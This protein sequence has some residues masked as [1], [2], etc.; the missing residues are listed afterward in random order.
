M[1]PTPE[2]SVIIVGAGPTG[3]ALACELAAA[4]VSCTVLER[5]TKPSAQ[6]RAMA[7]YSRTLEVLDLRGHA[8][9]L[10]AVGRPVGRM[11]PAQGAS[12]DFTGIDSPFPALYVVP[13]SR[14]EEALQQ[15]AI[16]LGVIV[17]RGAEVFGVEQDATG[18][19]L[20]VRTESG[21]WEETA[22][23]VVGCDGA[24]SAVREMS[25]IAFRG[26]TYDIAPILADVR[27][28]K[29]P[30]DD[31]VM[32]TGGGAM[33]VS[34]PFG[35]GL[36]RVAVGHRDHPWT[37]DE[38]TLEELAER[39][40]E[41]LG[42]DPEPYDAQ[43]LAR[44]KIHQR[45]ADQYR[46]GRVLLA[47]DAAHLHS[48]LG[49]QGLNLGIQ[50]AVN[51]GWKLAATIQGWAPAGLLD[52]YQS[53]RRPQAQR[54]LKATDHATRMATHPSPVVT[55][56]RRMVLSRLL[57]RRRINKFAGEAISGLRAGYA[58]RGR[59]VALGGARLRP[60]Q[61]VP[62]LAVPQAEGAP[63]RLY[64]LMRDGRFLLLD[65]GADG[66]AAAVCESWGS[67]VC[68]VRVDGPVPQLSG[69]STVLVR[70]DGYAAWVDSTSSATGR[71]ERVRQALH[72]WCG[73][74]GPTP[75]R[76]TTT[77]AE[78][79]GPARPAQEE[80]AEAPDSEPARADRT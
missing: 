42:F 66:T 34:V 67:R 25:G 65:L 27:L 36:Y 22:D 62:D 72:R 32:L 40:T 46:T 64:E 44:F 49:G 53:E 12:I 7:L 37:R 68:P 39:L 43:W 5:R 4:G 33:M 54:I 20:H 57:G 52:T 26:R 14:T 10:T 78:A 8:D 74:E 28:R 55:N 1:A 17:Q 63:V 60:G 79:A 23:Y 48:P 19:R 15:R 35:D 41:V 61:R 56:L 77:A 24:H 47:G 71:E 3:L 50:D 75:A 80:T 13:Q 31:V 9:A 58:G 76:R 70:P 2:Q 21:E 69:V 6:S 18:V 29:A 73:T 16:D 51:L 38:V 11:Q 59:P 45:L 30:P